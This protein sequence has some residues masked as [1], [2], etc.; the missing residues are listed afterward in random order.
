MAA[1]MGEINASS[2]RIAD[3]ID[4]IAFQTNLLAPNAVLEAARAGE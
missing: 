2:Q 3:I 1:A 4:E